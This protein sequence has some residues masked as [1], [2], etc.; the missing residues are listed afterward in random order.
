[1]TI[2]RLYITQPQLREKRI[3]LSDHDHHYLGRVLRMRK[4][5]QVAVL[6]GAGTVGSARIVEM[7]A[8]STVIAVESLE[9]LSE[10]TP[11]LEL[12]QALLSPAKMDRVVQDCAEAG[13]AAVTPFTCTRSRKMDESA[14]ERLE[15]WRKIAI[16]AWRLAGRAYMPAV[17]EP[18]TWDLLLLELPQAPVVLFA[19]ETGG[20]R[21]VEVLGAERPERVGL[22]VGPE[23]GFCDEERGQLSSAQAMPV[24]LGKGIFRAETAGLALSLAARCHYG[25]L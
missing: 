5:E 7:S 11:R 15:R 16:E 2:P 17:A 24:T 8:G 22:I 4:G 12:Y 20:R 21:P 3:I 19:D 25:F 6:D 23:G 18:I 14:A 10:E 1:M 13:V 9:H